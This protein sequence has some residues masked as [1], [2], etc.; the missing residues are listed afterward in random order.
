MR[1]QVV[2]S[3][4]NNICSKENQKVSKE[5]RISKAGIYFSKSIVG[6]CG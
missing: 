1:K 2:S 6:Y 5:N 3:E 4:E